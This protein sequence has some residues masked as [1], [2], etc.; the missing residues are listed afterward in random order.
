MSYGH[1]QEKEQALN[2]EIAD[3]TEK[4]KRCDQTKT[5]PTKIKRL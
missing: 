1:L 3:L 2:A 5:R 4:A